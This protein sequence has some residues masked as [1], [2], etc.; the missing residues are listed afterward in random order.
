[1]FAGVIRF[2]NW[3]SY[4][5]HARAYLSD[6]VKNEVSAFLLLLHA[7]DLLE[8]NGKGRSD[9]NQ[10]NLNNYVFIRIACVVCR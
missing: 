5:H 4:Y 2:S 9:L 7:F 8:A 3:N 1:M 10:G 6:E